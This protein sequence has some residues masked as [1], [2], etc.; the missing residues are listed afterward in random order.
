MQQDPMTENLQYLCTLFPSIAEVCRRMDLN[1]QQFNKYLN[2][3]VR[4][5]R[6]NLRIICDFFGITE[7]E[8]HMD[9]RR[10]AEIV[11]LRKG[12]VLAASLEEPQGHIESLYR[13]SAS[14]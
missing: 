10:L 2:G 9:T 6:H 5:S 12:P 3:Q 8:I 1:R 7:S 4:P 13:R 14:L 11:S